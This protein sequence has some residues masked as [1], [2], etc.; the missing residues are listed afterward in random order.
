VLSDD[1][2]AACQTADVGAMLR[3]TQYTAA[4]LDGKTC[5]SRHLGSRACA[6]ISA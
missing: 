6:D 4:T 1:A 3:L 5:V 2:F